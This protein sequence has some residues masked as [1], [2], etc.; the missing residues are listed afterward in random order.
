MAPI[1]LGKDT[2][3][4]VADSW[5][6]QE[7]GQGLPS[8]LFALPFVLF[9]PVTG[10]LADRISKT[11]IVRAANLIEIFVMVSGH[12]DP[13][14]IFKDFFHIL[15]VKDFVTS[16]PFLPDIFSGLFYFERVIPG[17]TLLMIK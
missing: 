10:S 14:N 16:K 8:A 4:W 11:R 15:D 6:A 5:I 3:G 1:A 2:V 12:H 7:Y 17:T 9:G 13:R